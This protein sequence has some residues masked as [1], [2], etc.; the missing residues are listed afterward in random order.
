MFVTIFEGT[1]IFLGLILQINVY[2]FE[3]Y[4]FDPLNIQIIK[5]LLCP[6]KKKKTKKNWVGST[7]NLWLFVALASKQAIARKQHD[8]TGKM[9]NPCGNNKPCLM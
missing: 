9:W 8:M 3:H 5:F 4:L 1:P 7:Q 2:L 6:K